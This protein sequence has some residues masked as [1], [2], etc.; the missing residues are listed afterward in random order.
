[1]E[2][3]KSYKYKNTKFSKVELLNFVFLFT[4]LMLSFSS[5]ITGIEAFKT[6]SVKLRSVLTLE[7]FVSLVAGYVYYKFL[8]DTIN[9]S[10]SNPLA[11][12]G[13]SYDSSIDDEF[14][15]SENIVSYD[16]R[17]LD[18]FITTPFLLLSL[19]IILNENEEFP[20]ASFGVVILLNSIMLIFGYMG[21]TGRMNKNISWIVSSLSLFIMF[22]IIYKTFDPLEN[23]VFWF[24]VVLWALYGIVFFIPY[25]YNVIL[26]S[27]LDV[28]A[29]AGL[30]IWTWLVSVG[31]LSSF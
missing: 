26:Y 12:R 21:E 11:G 13:F 18:W 16:Y 3:Q 31:L 29:K 8:S 4:F 22:V 27:I 5:V 1:M 6:D 28:I 25:E 7:T 17:Y 19:F 30:G 10:D 14:I 20:W 9:N 15:S 24:F 2:C 23:P